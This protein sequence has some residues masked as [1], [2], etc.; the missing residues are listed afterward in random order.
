MVESTDYFLS[1]DPGS[2]PS[3][4][5][6]AHMSVS[7]ACGTQTDANTHCRDMVQEMQ[8]CK[9][10]SEWFLVRKLQENKLRALGPRF[11]QKRAIVLEMCFCAPPR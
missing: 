7:Q 9:G 11:L 10:N 6:A 8:S 5:M 4:C 2:I 1:E 3:T